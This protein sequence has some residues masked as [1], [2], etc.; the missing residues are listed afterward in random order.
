M[1]TA[2][3]IEQGKCFEGAKVRDQLE[4][5]TGFQGTTGV[6]NMS[7]TVHQGI[8]VNPFLL[9]SIIGGQV[10]VVQVTARV[11][12]GPAALGALRP[13]R[14]AA[15]TSASRSRTAS[16]SPCSGPNGAGKTT[17]MRA[18]MGLVANSGDVRFRGEALPRQSPDACVAR[19]LVLVPEGRGIFAPMT[20]AENLELGAYLLQRRGRVRA[21][22]RARVRRC[23]R[24]CGSG[25]A[26]SRARCPAASS[27]CSRSAAR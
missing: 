6:Y 7:P 13:R 25:S 1:L 15:S 19:G 12:G 9:A 23:S 2:K 8:T 11:L 14:G 10:K 18:I 21:P 3:A 16:S 27:R 5:I 24:A 17:L 26:R 22:P 20:V 4:T